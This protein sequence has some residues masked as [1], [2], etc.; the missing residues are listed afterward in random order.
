MKIRGYVDFIIYPREHRLDKSKHIQ[1]AVFTINVQKKQIKCAG[2]VP[3]LAPGDYLEFDGEFDKDDCFQVASAMRVDDDEIGAASMVIFIFGPKTATKV[4]QQFHNKPLEAWDCFKNFEQRFYNTM[5]KVKGVGEKT[6]DKAY[7]KYENHIAVDVLFNKF[8]QYGLSLN[9][10]LAI[11]DAWGNQS[12]NK[13]E[14]NPYCLQF[15]DKIPFSIVDRIALNHYKL[16][17]TDARRIYAGVLDAMKSI[18]TLGH[19]FIRLQK[20]SYPNEPIL[21]A[22]VQRLL[23]IDSSLVR[24]AIFD[25]EKE[26]KLV[27]DKKGFTDIVYLPKVYEAEKGTAELV[28]NLIAQ[29]NIPDA[30]ID[31]CIQHFESS[32]HFTLADKQKEAVQTAVKNR[33]SIISGPPG[34]GKTTIMDVICEILQKM[35]GNCHIK[36]AAPTGKAAK[37]ITESTGKPAETVHRLLRYSPVD[38]KF[39]FDETNPLDMDVLIVDEFSMMSLSLT[40]SLLRAIPKYCCVIFVGDKEQLPSV[41][42]GNVLEDLLN[43]NYIPKVILNKIYRQ[44]NKSTILPRALD[45]SNDRMPNLDDSDDFIFWEEDDADV[46]K[47]GLLELYIA[48][49]KKYGVEN[50]MLLTPQ[51]TKSLGVDEL[52][53]AIQ[54]IY[55]PCKGTEIKSGKR[56]FRVH[57]RVIQ[58]TNEDDYGVYNG[59][60]GTITKIIMEDPDFGQKDTIV[61]DY[62]DITC[63]YTRDR[64]ENIKLAFAMT[65]HKC[66][67]SE[68]KSVLMVMHSQ[69][70]YMLRR[71]LIYTG[72]T[73]AKT[74]LQM[75]GQKE[76]IAYAIK[77]NKEP[78][79]NSK[80][81]NW[82]Q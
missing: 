19:S 12:M 38:K 63:E 49:V 62:G 45:I 24:E 37:R 18:N 71:R 56:A 3:F 72:M 39:E 79:R 6:I 82:L 9:K 14:A 7:S 5:L 54:E 48:E 36:L 15:L 33:F 81:I 32:N 10:A 76:M 11:Y 43:V 57:D 22:S 27:L 47:E 60:V 50:V 34:S 42:A 65:I 68:A 75:V 31:R 28:K 40:Y 70:R 73:R 23:Q 59:M 4:I 17:K 67:G 51:N 26:N 29:N 2:K 78:I 8:G 21:I 46:L 69:H 58:L 80:L 13:I 77:N 41:D 35:K 55:N 66:Q 53:T 52:N 64:F 25:L 61:V 1:F 16:D 30:F 44:D 74:M 20:E